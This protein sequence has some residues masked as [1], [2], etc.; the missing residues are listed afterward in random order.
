MAYFDQNIKELALF[1][2]EE[3]VV[4]KMTTFDL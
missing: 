2:E 3:A 4:G 1:Y